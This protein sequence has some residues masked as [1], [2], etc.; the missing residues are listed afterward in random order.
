MGV[1]Q[2]QDGFNGPNGNGNKAQV[3][4]NGAVSVQV[5]NPSGSG[6]WINFGQSTPK[7]VT[8]GNISTL[9]LSANPLRVFATLSNN[10]SQTIYFQY[11]TNAAWQAGYRLSPGGIWVINT[12]ELFLGQVNA[13]TQTGTVDIDVIEGVN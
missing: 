8:V 10:S 11:S 2:L 1:F 5:I 13:I 4:S 12:I 3:F 6:G 7:R 9:L